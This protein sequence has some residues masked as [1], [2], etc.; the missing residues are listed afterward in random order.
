MPGGDSLLEWHVDAAYHITGDRSRVGRLGDIFQG[1]FEGEGR[2]CL[3]AGEHLLDRST[4]LLLEA[5]LA[6]K[7]LTGQGGFL[8]E[9]DSLQRACQ[10]CGRDVKFPLAIGAE[11]E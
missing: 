7:L 6:Q 5:R 10:A 11:L 4:G 1:R 8:Q 3:A 9:P 2:G